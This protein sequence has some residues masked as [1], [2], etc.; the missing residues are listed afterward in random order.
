MLRLGGG[1]AAV[2]RLQTALGVTVD[3]R[4]GPATEDAVRAFQE[5]V[6]LPVDGLVG[7][8]TWEALKQSRDAKP[9]AQ[10]TKMDK[11]AA[12]VI[13]YGTKGGAGA[14]LGAVLDRAPS[15]ALDLVYYGLA[16]VALVVAGVWAF[17]WARDTV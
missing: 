8:R 2:R 9:K 7:A 10:A 5:R 1:G 11:I 12:R 17:R 4:F 14:G 3:G 15:G 16:G 6:G 13:E